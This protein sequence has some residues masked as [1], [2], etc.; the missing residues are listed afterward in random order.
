MKS[1]YFFGLLLSS[2]AALATVGG[3]GGEAATGGSGGRGG[4]DTAS[5]STASSTVSSTTV[6]SGTGGAPGPCGADK[7]DNC[8][9]ETAEEAEINA[10]EV[11]GELEPVD[12]DVDYY[13]FEGKKG[14]A[15]YIYTTAKTGMDPFSP[16]DPDLVITMY[17]E[18]EQQIAENDDPFPRRSND[19]EI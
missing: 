16:E 12:E 4:D 7:D 2:A 15:L 6:G 8:G 5:S 9:F 18:N 10:E 1:K 17:D 14:Q 13:T 11:E 3:C 19:S